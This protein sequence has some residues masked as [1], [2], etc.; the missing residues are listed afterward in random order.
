MVLTGSWSVVRGA[1]IQALTFRLKIT[2]GLPDK[3]IP[4]IDTETRAVSEDHG[5]LPDKHISKHSFF[6][7]AETLKITV[8]CPT[9][10][11]PSVRTKTRVLQACVHHKDLL[12][13]LHGVVVDAEGLG[14]GG[15]FREERPLSPRRAARPR[16]SVVLAS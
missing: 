6:H 15:A 16:E 1:H 10:T 12:Q 13:Q 4:S 2:V 5:R 7:C 9:K 11:Y 3:H 14:L 8:G